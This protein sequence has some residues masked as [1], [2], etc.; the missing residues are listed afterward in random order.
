[1]IAKD[2]KSA[3]LIKPFLFGREIKRYQPLESLQYL[4]LIPKGWTRLTSRGQ[5]NAW[6]WLQRDHPAI[7]AH[8]KRFAKPAQQRCDQGEYWWELR[9]CDYYQEFD[10]P[11]LILPDISRRGH[12]AFDEAGQ[13]YC[14][15]T[16][17]ILPTADL[18]L[19]GLLNSKLITFYYKSLSAT[20]RGGYL[21]FIYQYLI[22]LPIR[23]ID[24]HN[25]TDQATHDY[26]V[27]LV[28][29]MRELHKRLATP[30]DSH[31]K[32]VLKRRLEA[33][34][35]E[36]DKVVYGLYNLTAEEIEMVEKS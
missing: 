26:L 22:Q 36:I 10:K 15:N 24:Y 35:E 25:P 28:T 17:Y 27:Q 4:I 31:S 18:Y 20:Y 6:K 9:A 2:P 21:R 14:S 34:D 11:K 32:T 29:Q 33:V 19:L 5:T 30:L 13:F 1:L 23:P 8:L 16:A 3:E 7:A 12:F